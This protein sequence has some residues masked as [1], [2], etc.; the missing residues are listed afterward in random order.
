MI[1]KLITGAD[2]KAKKIFYEVKSLRLELEILK[3][4]QEINE[5]EFRRAVNEYVRLNRLSS[6]N[7]IFDTP[8]I[9]TPKS[10]MKV[11][12]SDNLKK[13]YK[14]IAMKTHPD[15]TK[16][17]P[18]SYQDIMKKYHEELS[19][20]FN[21]NCPSVIIDIAQKLDFENFDLGIEEYMTLQGEKEEILEEIKQIKNT[22]SWR[23]SNSNKDEKWIK[24]FLGV[25]K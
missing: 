9:S 15:K 16:N 6:R 11:D 17:F 21:S 13:L 10:A 25:K 4:D 24:L 1:S 14:K 20:G 7:V 5:N 18:K 23:W 8:D 12:C 3:E 22:Y 19:A 2:K